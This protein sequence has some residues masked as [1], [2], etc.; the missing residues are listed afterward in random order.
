MPLEPLEVF[1]A[2][3]FELASVPV[4]LHRFA[5]SEIQIEKSSALS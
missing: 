3:L 4:G 1:S 5:E 2:L